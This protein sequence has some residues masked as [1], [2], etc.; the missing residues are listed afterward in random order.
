MCS[1]LIV[2][3]CHVF[4][5]D[6]FL[7]DQL[8]CVNSTLIVLTVTCSTLIAFSCCLDTD[9][10]TL[11]FGL[12][13]CNQE[14]FRLNLTGSCLWLAWN[15]KSLGIFLLKV[16]TSKPR[17]LNVQ[18]LVSSLGSLPNLD[19]ILILPWDQKLITL[20]LND[21]GRSFDDI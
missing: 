3:S 19:D 18:T 16:G 6:S 20:I 17:V 14:V 13:S 7:G 2:F 10:F 1:T 15:R 8:S 11:G 5:L 21:A 4:H 9:V 12:S